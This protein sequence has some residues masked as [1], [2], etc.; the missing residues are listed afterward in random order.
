MSKRNRIVIGLL[1]AATL[2]GLFVWRVGK[3]TRVSAIPTAGNRAP[4]LEANAL[5]PPAGESIRPHFTDV[6]GPEN[7]NIDFE[8]NNDEVPGRFFL[9]ES[10]GGAASWIDYDGDG[11]LDLYLTNGRPLASQEP[12]T[13]SLSRLYRNLGGD[14]FERVSEAASASV[15]AYGHGCG[16]GD[17][18][19]DGFP[20]LYLSNFGPNV[21]LRNNGDGTFENVT[22]VAGVG[23]DLWSFAGVWLDVED[24]HDLDLYVVNYLYWS[25]ANTQICNYEGDKPGYCGPG[26]YLAAPDRLYVNQGDGTFHEEAASWGLVGEQGKGLVAIAVDLDDDLQ[27]EIYVGNDL[28][29]N[30]LF[31]RTGQP[32]VDHEAGT[33]TALFAETGA[34][35]G[36]AVS[37][38]GDNEAT[39]GVACGDYNR[40]GLPDLFL[41][42]YYKHKN[43]LYSNLGELQFVDDSV[44]THV[45]RIS[46]ESLGFGTVTFDYDRDG[47]LD[48]F[49]A[50][51]HVLGPNIQPFAMRPQLLRNDK[52]GRFDDASDEAGAYFS[53]LH[54]GRGV[55]S[56]DYD[57]DGDVD[58]AVS[59]LHGR[60][61]LLRND[62]Q[63]KR[64]FLG[65]EL[66][67]AS[68]IPPVGG[69]VVV[70][71]RQ[72]QQ[73]HPV[74]SGGTYVAT[75]DPRLLFGLADEE[76][77]D[78]EI[79]WP[80]GRMDS[81][82]NLGIDRYWLIIEG[83]LPQAA[84]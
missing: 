1:G 24:D 62:T 63:T 34:A 36:V 76:Q 21:L 5:Q 13:E 3:S 77:V 61:A 72:L 37:G 78:V 44:R 19:S 30:F 33:A 10:M 60:V 49:V 74:V 43:T 50:N 54:L 59:H 22:A 42:H 2:A 31:T 6:A 46:W 70:R 83:Q 58:L 41:A 27:P 51:G 80:S 17:F 14:R 7:A 55:A 82:S 28:T 26:K 84:Q 75:N 18:D 68:R 11:A 16:V 38:D 81:F 39:M 52:S 12:Q 8:Y 45:A 29:P 4:V 57:D 71:T 25:L 65:I 32:R 64:H 23:D 40:D 47:W 35:A 20:D 66:Q 56:G 67:T 15:D 69:R 79:H 9:P 53:D 73:I 48:L